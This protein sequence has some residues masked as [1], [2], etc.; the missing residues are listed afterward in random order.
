MEWEALQIL[1]QAG[2]LTLAAVILV[3]G[4]RLGRLWSKVEDLLKL[5]EER[6]ERLSAIEQRLGA[7]ESRRGDS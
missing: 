1:Q 3:A 5:A 6:D 7:L 2:P 4:M